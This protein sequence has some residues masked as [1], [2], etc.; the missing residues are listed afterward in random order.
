G[1]LVHYRLTGVDSAGNVSLPSA[2]ASVTV[3]ITATRLSG[4]N[5]YATAIASSQGAFASAQDII[6]ATGQAYPDALAASALAGVL[7]AP[8][9]LT[10]H[11]MLSA[12]VL[13][14][15]DRLGARRVVIVG[16]DTAVGPD[17][18]RTLHAAGL[19]TR[20]LAGA[21]RY[22]TAAL[23][24]EETK[25]VRVGTTLPG[26]A[27][28]VRG[29]DFP[30]ALAIAPVAYAATTPV[31]LVRPGDVPAATGA[32][33][34]S[35]GYSAAVV[36]GGVGAISQSTANALGV[37]FERV[38]GNDRF[39]TSAAFAEWATGRGVAGFRTLAL[40]TGSAFPDALGGGAA[41]GEAGGVL[42]LTAHD[43]LSPALEPV[44]AAHAG[45]LEFLNIYGGPSAVSSAVMDRAVQ[46]LR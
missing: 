23:I 14:E 43:L 15:I 25:R 12:E 35:G 29:D 11:D 24:A 21:D 46:L 37:P 7:H 45:E 22:A 44:L 26:T 18:E 1:Q 30:D 20:R 42:L 9:L 31:L 40:A 19:Y 17:V 3:G 4:D 16:G 27:L 33:L 28:V 5:R 13:A 36:V 34:A 39:A 41:T 32:A 38:Q 2:S 6:L 8:V 10:R